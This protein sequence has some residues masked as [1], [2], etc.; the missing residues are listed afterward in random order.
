M[1]RGADPALV[2]ALSWSFYPVTLVRIDWPGGVVRV[3]SGVAPLEWD[4]ETWLGVGAFGGLRLPGDMAGLASMEGSMTLGGLPEDIDS[5]L[6]ANA[7]GSEVVVWH[8]ALT[9]RTGS[10]PGGDVLV[11]P[12][13]Q[14]WSGYCDGVESET[15]RTQGGLVSSVQVALVSR[16]SQ[17]GLGSAVHTLEDQAAL[18][19]GDTAGRHVAAA[20]ALTKAGAIKW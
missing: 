13:V 9:A 17:R 12:P 2:A 3:H 18:F 4:S 20:L 7:R 15:A 8:G 11:A 19:P 14:A 16:G 1:S 5:I 10:L 6:T